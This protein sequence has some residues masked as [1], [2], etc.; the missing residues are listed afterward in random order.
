LS[1]H[2][3]QNFYVIVGAAGSTL[4][5]IQ[6]VVMTLVATIRYHQTTADSISAFGTPTV[7]HFAM[8]LFLA[9][10]MNVPWPSL[11]PASLTIAVCA[12]AALGYSI[13]VVRRARRQTTYE[14]VQEDWLWYAILPC[15][16]YATLAVAAFLLRGFT[17]V[18][19]FLIAA[20][21]VALLL[22]GIHNAWDTVTYIVV[23]SHGHEEK[24]EE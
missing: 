4:I 12:L 21:A 17:T 5:G 19:A 8:A 20:S 23:S 2:G 13:V 18:A 22:I 6:F 9:A 3:W 16:A 10:V 7:V 24:R 11:L 15:S 1:M 14:T